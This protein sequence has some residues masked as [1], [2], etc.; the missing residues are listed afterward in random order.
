MFY[1]YGVYVW[2]CPSYLLG[3]QSHLID[4][5]GNFLVQW[6]KKS[7]FVL[8]LQPQTKGKKKSC[9]K[10]MV[11]FL[12]SKRCWYLGKDSQNIKRTGDITWETFCSSSCNSQS[13][14]DSSL[15]CGLGKGYYE[16][17]KGIQ[18]QGTHKTITLW[19]QTDFL[20]KHCHLSLV[21]RCF[22]TIK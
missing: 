5:G 19:P 14:L 12:P 6:T 20:L 1:S 4:P 2:I 9:H 3:E 8:V 7:Y 22:A 13:C 10:N 21:F 16:W 11:T 15:H 17:W 18:E